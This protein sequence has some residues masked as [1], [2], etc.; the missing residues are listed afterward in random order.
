MLR[1]NNT[2]LEKARV[3]YHCFFNRFIEMIIKNRKFIE[4]TRI[5]YNYFLNR[6]ELAYK[7]WLNKLGCNCCSLNNDIMDNETMVSLII[8]I[9]VVILLII[10]YLIIEKS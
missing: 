7:Y 4:K 5:E 10:F 6:V 8:T 1:R 9:F 3:E 2:I